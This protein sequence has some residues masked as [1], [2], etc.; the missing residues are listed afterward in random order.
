MLSIGTL[1]ITALEAEAPEAEAPLIEWTE[2]FYV[3]MP[4]NCKSFLI[5]W[6]TVAG[7]AEPKGDE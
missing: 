1:I 6:P 2:N 7:V 3:S 5:Q 4:T